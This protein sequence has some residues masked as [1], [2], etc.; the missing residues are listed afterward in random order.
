MNA[1]PDVNSVAT[2]KTLL[3]LVLCISCFNP[4]ASRAASDTVKAAVITQT[5]DADIRITEPDRY[6]GRQSL[7]AGQILEVAGSRGLQIALRLDTN[8]AA[9]VSSRYLKIREC[10]PAELDQAKAK[11]NSLNPAA[12]R[13]TIIAAS[14][15]KLATAQSLACSTC[16]KQRA[17]AGAV[18]QSAIAT[19]NNELK[20][21][22][23]KN[24]ALL[25]ESLAWAA[26]K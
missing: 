7:G 22:E 26:G 6:A 12:A 24:K 14:Q 10:T 25:A 13:K 23:Q 19:R 16:P 9:L 3:S 18:A 21:L 11:F 1:I 17:R 20:A 4:A 2:I 15:Q 8:H 5:T